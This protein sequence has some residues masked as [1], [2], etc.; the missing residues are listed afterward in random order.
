MQTQPRFHSGW[1]ELLYHAALVA[2]LT[3]IGVLAFVNFV[4]AEERVLILGVSPVRC[5]APCAIVVR[6]VARPNPDNEKIVL[7]WA[8]VLENDTNNGTRQYFDNIADMTI[9]EVPRG[10]YTV[11]AILYRKGK[12]VSEADMFVAVGME[13]PPGSRAASVRFGAKP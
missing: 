6:A 8:N 5:E 13:P 4:Q 12:V 7:I 3:A 2:L 9:T 11:Q 10:Y 1:V